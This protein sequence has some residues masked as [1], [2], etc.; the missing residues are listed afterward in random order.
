M[1]IFSGGTGTPKLLNGLREVI[2]EE[3]INV[4]VN[5]AE[6][7]WISGNLITPDID[8]V[9]YLFSG[10]LD[11][12]RWWGIKGDTYR[13]HETMKELG[14]NEVMM[15]GDLDR[16]THIMRSDLIRGGMTLSEAT[17]ELCRSFGLKIKVLPMSDDPVS[18]MISTPEGKMHFQDFWVG[19]HGAPEVLEVCQEGIENASISPAVMDALEKE[20]EVLLGPSNPITS[21]GPVIELPGMR[22]ILMDKKVVAVSPIIGTEPV[23]GPAGKLMIARGIEVSSYGVASYYSDFLDHMVIDERDT[24]DE[25]RFNELGLDVSKADTLMRSVDISRDLSL[26]L[27]E[28]F[29]DI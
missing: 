25:D 6:D 9:L 4:V 10:R 12:S 28:I 11:S 13:T 23:S 27:L 20:D 1:I 14:H 18:S 3:E 29:R 2:P 21:I 16:A 26:T 7:V 19:K 15:L 8:T 24:I 17:M 5:T 22:E